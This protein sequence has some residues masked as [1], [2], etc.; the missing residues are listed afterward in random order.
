MFVAIETQSN[1]QMEQSRNI[2]KSHHTAVVLL[3]PER[4]Q[5]KLQP[6]IMRPRQELRAGACQLTVEQTPERN[7]EDRERDDT[8]KATERSSKLTLC[9]PGRRI[10]GRCR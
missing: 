4:L 8:L 3:E 10:E 5:L 7:T 6:V 2:S 9:F 1:Q